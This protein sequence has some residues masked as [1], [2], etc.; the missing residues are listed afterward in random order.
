MHANANVSV[1]EKRSLLRSFPLH[2]Y[3]LHIRRRISFRSPR[4]VILGGC[5]ELVAVLYFFSQVKI[6]E[7]DYFRFGPPLLLF[8]YEITSYADFLLLLGVFFVH[9]VCYTWITE[10]INPWVLNEVQDHKCPEIRYS[11]PT[12]LWVINLYTSYV[13]VNTILILNVAFSQLSFLFVVLIADVISTTSLNLSYIWNK[14]V[15]CDDTEEDIEAQ[16]WL[17][18]YTPIPAP[19]SSAVSLLHAA[20]TSPACPANEVPVTKP[21]AA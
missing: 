18:G 10:T 8:H 19:V 11:K 15:I 16:V 9:Q 12:T 3:L 1:P 5:L 17:K 7:G 20:M 4:A 6:L 2:N 14:T 13:T 21:Q